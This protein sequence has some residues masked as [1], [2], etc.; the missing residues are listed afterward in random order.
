MRLLMK[1]IQPWSILLVAALF[2]FSGCAKKSEVNTTKMEQSFASA[3]P[4]NKSE[5]DKAVASIKAG[6]YQ[7]AVGSLQKLAS[8]AQLTPQQKDA[9]KDVIDQV[10]EKLKEAMKDATKSTDKAM[11]DLKKSMPK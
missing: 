5:A 1:I 2:V 10:Q 11:D 3:D 4:A 7:S 9:V 6:D 8:Q